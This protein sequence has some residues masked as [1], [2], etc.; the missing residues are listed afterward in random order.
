MR[1]AEVA[2]ADAACVDAYVP[3][4]VY[5]Y[6]VELFDVP[7]QLTAL[8][9]DEGTAPHY[10]LATLADECARASFGLQGVKRP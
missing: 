2:Q 9:Y 3:A 10:K 8:D 7:Y 5:G 6:S 4:S 1:E